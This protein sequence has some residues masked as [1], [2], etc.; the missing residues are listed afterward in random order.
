MNG[1]FPGTTGGSLT[2]AGGTLTLSGANTYTGP[3]SI[4]RGTLIVNGV[5]TSDVSVD[6]GATL[7]G[8]GSVG[9]VDV[10][11]VISPGSSA[12]PD[13]GIGTLN[14]SG[15]AV[16]ADAA[17][18]VEANAAG[19]SDRLVVSDDVTLG[20]SRL[21][22]FAAG[23]DYAPSTSYLVIDKTAAGAISGKF[24][25]ITSNSIFVTP[26]L[27]YDG[28]TGNDAVLTLDA[29]AYET[30]AETRNQRAV[31]N[32]LDAAPFG[33]LAASIFYLDEASAREAFTALAGEVHPTTL[34]ILAEDSRFLR[35]AV[36]GRAVQAQYQGSGSDIAISPAGG[37]ETAEGMAASDAGFW[38]QGFGSWAS[39]DGDGNAAGGKR[40]LGGFVS[41]L[42]VGLDGGWRLGAAAGYAQSSIILDAQAGS[43]DVDTFSHRGLWRRR[44]WSGRP[45]GRCGL[46]LA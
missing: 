46:E 22:V 1:V 36:L 41:G 44:P 11:G 25:E 15:D 38:A 35:Q 26:S 33:A 19:A 29:V 17:F 31:A 5:I 23:G 37:V 14:I 42:D 3:T 24:S 39:Y 28:G 40:D 20:N 32:A 18:L 27:V 10:A 9:S 45:A 34:G 12:A 2:L 7:A 6:P 16:L 21:L 4:E 30:F 13:H 43:A 8:I